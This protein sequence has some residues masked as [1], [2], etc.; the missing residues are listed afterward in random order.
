MDE[1]L[2]IDAAE[3]YLNGE[4]SLQ[5]RE[6]FETYRNSNPEVDKMIAEHIFFIQE[7]QKYADL[8]KFQEHLRQCMNENP[9][10]KKIEESRNKGLIVSIWKQYRKTAAVAAS[11][12]IFASV[13][14]TS[15]LTTYTKR[16]QPNLKPLVE[17][18]N[19]NEQDVRN[20]QNKVVKLS[21]ET[22]S[23]ISSQKPRINSNFRATG[24]IIDAENNL[25]V[26]NAHV[27]REA[28]HKL[29]VENNS[30]EQFEAISIYTDANSD[31]AIL[32]ITDPEFKKMAPIPYLL[33]NNQA[34]LGESIFTLGYPKQEIVYG[35][36]YI[37]AE[38]GYKMDTSFFQLSTAANEGNSGSPVISKDGKIIGV[39]SST[40]TDAEG[41][42]FAVKSKNILNA[43]QQINP[44]K[45]LGSGKSSLKNND[46]ITQIK[47]VQ[48]YIF[49][50]KGN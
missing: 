31:L 50:I 29:F 24:F 6:Y 8:R 5:E 7:M 30:G 44:S 4:M 2:L 19:E 13:L 45:K 48:D 37:S 23:I 1:I 35:E 43:L 47:K 15:L 27:V 49:M 3:R 36:G 9:S 41:V 38:N 17:K 16:N 42:V 11:I 18:I 32:Q 22:N 25:L 40:E 10:D 33:D 12:T 39:I 20:L 46:R 26:T 21:N 14:C 28:S 34:N